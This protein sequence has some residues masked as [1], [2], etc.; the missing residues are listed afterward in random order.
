VQYSVFEARLNA[1]A[2]KRLASAVQQQL[3]SG[4]SLRVYT[5]GQTGERQCDVYGSG[6]PI[7]PEGAFW[8]L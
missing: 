3:E 1:K 7:E 2:A 6:V 4:D 5:V 8:L